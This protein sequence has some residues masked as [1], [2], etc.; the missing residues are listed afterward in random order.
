[1]TKVEEA[2]QWMWDEL[3][4]K[5]S[6]YQPKAVDEIARRFGKEFTPLNERGNPSIR[7]DI[8]DLFKKLHGGKAKWFGP[9]DNY[10][11]L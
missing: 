3:Q 10:W 8:R 7:R 5:R 6:L 2:A 1:M 11:T 4:A 9:P